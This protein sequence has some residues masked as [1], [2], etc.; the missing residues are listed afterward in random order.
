MSER[1][2]T[3]QL[4]KFNPHSITRQRSSAHRTSGT[5]S[6]VLPLSGAKSATQRAEFLAS[7][8]KSI[9]RGSML[10]TDQNDPARDHSLVHL[11]AEPCKFKVGEDIL[12]EL[13]GD[14][15]RSDTA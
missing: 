5:Y 7:C 15:D 13:D 11:F 14:I 3:N 6:D 9:S 8:L 10:E 1:I 4:M 2:S 12:D